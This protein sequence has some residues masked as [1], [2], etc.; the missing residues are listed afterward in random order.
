MSKRFPGIAGLLVAL[1]LVVSFVVPANMVS[2]TG[3]S[4]D[5]GILEWTIV[6]TPD[7]IPSYVKEIYSPGV[8]NGPDMGSEILK[9]LIGPDGETMWA[10]IGV[11]H[12]S[13]TATILDPGGSGVTITALG[14]Q[15]VFRKST[16]GGRVWSGTPYAN[17]QAD[18]GFGADTLIWDI[19][20][21]PDDVNVAIVAVSDVGA[22]GAETTQSVWITTDGGGNWDNTQWPGAYVPA[23]GTEFI[24]AMDISIDYGDA[25]KILVGTR[26]PTCAIVAPLQVM[27][28]PGYGGWLQQSV[29]PA[30]T[31]SVIDAKFSPTFG[32]DS[33][34]IVLYTDGT[35]AGLINPGDTGTFLITGNH[36]IAANTTDWTTFGNPIEIMNQTS[37]TG[38]SPQATEIIT[39]QIALPSDYSGQS[40]SL[41]RVY[42]AT[43]ALDRGG[44][45]VKPD[46]GVYRIDDTVVYTLMDNTATFGT[47]AATGT[48]RRAASLA[49]WGTYASGKLLVGERLGLSCTASVPVWFT[50]SPTVCPIPC[51]YPS[52]KPPTGAANVAACAS[53]THG[54][55]NAWVVWSPKYADQGVADAVTGAQAL[56]AAFVAPPVFVAGHITP[57]AAIANPAWPNGIFN[58]VKYDESAMSLTRNNGE[59]FNQM[60]LIDTLMAKLTDVAVSADCTTLYLASINTGDN[61]TTGACDNFDSVWRTTSNA[62]VVDPPLPALP[63]GQ[64]WERV[65]TS[66]TAEDCTAV[67]SQYAI[68]R[69]APDKLDGQIVF[70]GAGGV[71]GDNP[72]ANLVIGGLITGGNTQAVAWSPDYGDYWA[73]INPRITVQD[74]AAESSTILYVLSESGRVQKLPYTGTAWSSTVATT[75]SNIGVGHTIEALAEGNVLVTAGAGRAFAATLS[76]NSAA[77]FSSWSRTPLTTG[78]FHAIFDPDFATNKLVY[79]ADDEA[80]QSQNPDAT[81]WLASTGKIYRSDA[82]S[83]SLEWTDMYTN[84]SFWNFTT[85]AANAVTEAN[86][87]HGFYGLVATNAKNVTAQPTLYAATGANPSVG[88]TAVAQPFSSVMRTL[89]PRSGI[90]KPGISWDQLI[91]TAAFY[92][93]FGVLFTLE[94]KSLKFCGC[95]TDATN[96]TLYAIDNDWYANNHNVRKNT[97]VPE[98]T[99]PGTIITTGTWPP[100]MV[101]PRTGWPV[102][103]SGMLWAYEDC[104]AKRGPKLTMDDGTIIGCDPATG[105]NQEVN[106]TWEQLCV[107]NRYAIHVAKDSKFTL[108]VLSL[109]ITPTS[110]TSPTFIY[111]T[112]GGQ[113]SNQQT[114][115][116]QPLECGH[117]YYWRVRVRGAVT[118]EVLRSPYSDVRSF[119]IKAGFRVTTP[120]YGPQ[121]LEPINGCGCACDAPVNFSWSPFKETQKYKFELSENADMSSPVVSVEVPTTAYQYKGTAKCN[122]TYFW[123]VMA[124]DPAP[125]EWSAVFSFKTQKAVVAPTPTPV[126]EEKTPIWVWVLIAIGAILVIVTL[127]LIFKT[128][129]V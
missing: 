10:I 97:W 86:A 117:K 107:D 14:A 99:G 96:T 61:T 24:S 43:D 13:G 78:N 119:T 109:T 68:L 101:A 37:V 114:I 129:R 3:V 57:A 32:G 34:I 72:V 115:A 105:R 11:G 54:Y 56:D 79:A 63:I 48:V 53:N 102:R 50:D 41:R 116:Y 69:L 95:L 42:V 66:P 47:V 76:T 31:G 90:P 67:Q 21:A 112:G 82:D 65:R 113:I 26:D 22:V 36:D 20:I 120:Y 103:S 127:V 8:T 59:T 27:K 16:N 17:L 88:P 25:R 110:V 62:A 52:K 29:L 45:P 46:R 128:R 33:T 38:D 125:S 94:P 111:W 51:W 118:G 49:Y 58:V 80:R 92:Q 55:G 84:G 28:V 106:F 71:E 89:T 30:F 6:D 124:T 100:V 35:G 2:P 77:S 23:P 19:A 85:V 108:R 40:A 60:A 4:A 91:A 18:T 9:L 70:W 5:P 121:L 122:Q 83:R 104:V 81:T 64:V 126:P 12:Q 73:N 75:N 15:V 7:S 39:G 44:A 123:R 87:P 74:M 98:T 93:S 1:L